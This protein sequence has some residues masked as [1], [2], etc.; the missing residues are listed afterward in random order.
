MS[1]YTALVGSHHRELRAAGMAISLQHS[2]DVVLPQSVA[3]RLRQARASLCMQKST[4]GLVGNDCKL[5]RVALSPLMA[6]QG[7]ESLCVLLL[8]TLS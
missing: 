8:H 5:M 4:I 1:H 2:P 6:W 7:C 3:K